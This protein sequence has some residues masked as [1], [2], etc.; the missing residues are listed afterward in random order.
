MK[1]HPVVV[2]VNYT[3]L[4]LIIVNTI[5]IPVCRTL[6]TVLNNEPLNHGHLNISP[7][8]FNGQN[9]LFSFGRQSYLS[10]Y[11]KT[12]TP[13]QSRIKMKKLQI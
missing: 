12:I 6:N 9:D 11:P 5:C 4:I 2:I 1:F 10:Y 7:S 8:P 13:W 3:K